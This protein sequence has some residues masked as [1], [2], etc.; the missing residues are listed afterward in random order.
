MDQRGFLFG[1]SSIDINYDNYYVPQVTIQFVDIRGI[2]LFN[3]EEEAHN[4]TQDG[5]DGTINPDYAGS[6]FRS[7]FSFPYPIF[8]LKVKGFYGKPISYELKSKEISFK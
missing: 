4:L 2:S 1:I 3:P 5:V 6:F 8:T 7:F